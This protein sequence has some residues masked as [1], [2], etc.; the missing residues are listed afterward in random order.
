MTTCSALAAAL[1]LAASC[2][3]AGSPGAKTKECVIKL[4]EPS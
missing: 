1:M 4:V 3:G 2:S